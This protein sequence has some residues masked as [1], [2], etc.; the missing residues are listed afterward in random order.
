MAT[1]VLTPVFRCTCIYSYQIQP[2]REG[3][4]AMYLPLIGQLVQRADLL[5]KQSP[6][7]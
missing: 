1:P 2:L 3:V 5:E 7:E 4:A 6:G